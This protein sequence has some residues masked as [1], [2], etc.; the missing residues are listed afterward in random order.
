MM[1]AVHAKRR[2]NHSAEEMFDLVADVERYPEFVPHCEKHV[3][4]SRGTS[5]NV[6]FLVTDMTMARGIFRVTIRG[7]DTL[8]RKNGRILIEA[9]AG[10]LRRLRTIWTFHPHSSESCDVGFDLRYEFSNPLMEFVLGGMLD[11]MFR[12]FVRAFER[13][14]DVIYGVSQVDQ[15]DLSRGVRASR[16]RIARRKLRQLDDRGRNVAPNRAAL[17]MNQ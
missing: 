2:V 10:P 4:V 7:R 9:T 15:R 17:D 3:I 13:R 1:P 16:S 6:Q 12:R 8:D 11:S 14:A 5:G